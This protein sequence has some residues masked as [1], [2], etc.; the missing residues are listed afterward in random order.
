MTTKYSAANF[1]VKPWGN[2]VLVAI[3]PD[4]YCGKVL[5]LWSEHRSSL[6]RHATKFETLY[7]VEGIVE[8]ETGTT[9][10][11]V[12]SRTLCNGDSTHIPPATWHR[13]SSRYGATVIEFSSSNE[14]AEVHA[15][16]GGIPRD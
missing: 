13:F 16:G 3:E 5:H 12:E 14:G 8:V 10:D 15:D 1:T 9:I 4:R 11:S 6:H 7:V 2:E